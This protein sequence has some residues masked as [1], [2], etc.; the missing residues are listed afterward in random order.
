M[1]AVKGVGTNI[2]HFRLLVTPLSAPK[3]PK[4]LATQFCTT[5]PIRAH[6]SLPRTAMQKLSAHALQFAGERQKRE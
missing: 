6:A 2:Y 4:I 1:K 5:V 3:S